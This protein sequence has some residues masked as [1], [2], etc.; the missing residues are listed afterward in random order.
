MS[1]VRPLICVAAVVLTLHSRAADAPAGDALAPWR[2]GVTIK[3]VSDAPGRHTTHAYYLTNPESPDGTKLLFFS[4]KTANG[5]SGEV[6]VLDRVT[7]KE[8]VIARNVTCEDAHRV[9]CQQ[10]TLGGKAVAY[11]DVREGKWGVYVVDLDTGKERAVAPGLQIGFG[12]PAGEWLPVYG[13]HWNPGEHRGLMLANARTGEIRTV[14]SIEQIEKMYADYL[15]MQFPGKRVSV[16]FP[17]IS[18]DLK[19]AFFKFAAGAG[20]DN[21]R[22]KVSDRQGLAVAN[23]ETGQLEFQHDRWGHPAWY[24]NSSKILEVNHVFLDLTKQKDRSGR[25]PGMP[26]LNGAPH[27]SV[28]PDSRLF[29][30]DGATDKIGGKPG[31]FCVLLGD[32]NGGEG[33]YVVLHKFMASGGAKSWRRNHPHPIFSAD[34]KRIYFNV[35]EGPWTQLYVAEIGP[36]T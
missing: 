35:N 31:E 16:F 29:V 32:I 4:S 8:T 19:H 3:P 13:T 5:E 18:P 2:A 6:V 1:V 26:A 11:H 17:V 27:P 24:P 30:T 14:T 15:A 25:I 21:F 33:R 7:G 20:G 28:S 12:Q 23:L 36:G 9:A 10:W 22:G 34:G